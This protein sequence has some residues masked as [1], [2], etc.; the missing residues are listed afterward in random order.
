M[1][2]YKGTDGYRAPEIEN[3]EQYYGHEVDM[4]AIGVTLFGMITGCPVGYHQK[5]KDGYDVGG[6]ADKE[7]PIYKCLVENQLHQFWQMHE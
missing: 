2:S 6:L 4:F 3:D 5:D 7:D 1:K